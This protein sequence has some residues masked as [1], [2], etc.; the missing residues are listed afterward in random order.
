MMTLGKGITGGY[1]PL[2][3]VMVSQAIARHF[4]ANVLWCG[5]TNYGHPLCCAAAN[6][7]IAAYET[8]GLI[9][10]AHARGLELATFLDRLAV[11]HPMIAEVRHIGLLAAIDLQKSSDD[12]SPWV[13][14]RAKGDDAAK[15]AKLQKAFYDA[16]LMCLVRFGTIL[17]APPLCIDAKELQKGLA[18]VDNVLRTE[19]KP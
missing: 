3:A 19:L 7:A 15:V 9:D 8:E 4:D 11:D 5:L 16:G 6:A 17:L 13:P 12:K 1:A 10:N 14:Y 18:I 2:S